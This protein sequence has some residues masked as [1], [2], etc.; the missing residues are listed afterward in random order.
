MAVSLTK[1]KACVIGGSRGK[2]MFKACLVVL[3]T[4]LLVSAKT[5]HADPNIATA[6]S[7]GIYRKLDADF[8]GF[9]SVFFK[10]LIAHRRYD[11]VN[12]ID[13]LLQ[14]ASALQG[15][16]NALDS[17]GLI[18]KNYPAVKK[19]ISSK[20]I[21]GIESLLLA[22]NEFETANS[23]FKLVKD[24]GDPTLITNVQFIFTKYYYQHGDWQHTIELTESISNDL[25]PDELQH[26]KFMEGIALQNQKKHRSAI[27]SFRKVSETSPYY[28]MAQLNMAVSDFRQDWW[29]DAHDIIN[30]LLKNPEITR[31]TELADRLH[32]IIGYSFLQLEY[33][34][35]SRNAFRN[36][37]LNSNYTNKALI[38]IALD[39]AYQKDY[40]GAL[41]AARI[42][43]NKRD[44]TLEVDEAH[45]L[46]PYFYEKLH[47]NAT[48]SAGYTS[49]ITYYEGRIQALQQ[50]AL[51]DIDEKLFAGIDSKNPGLLLNGEVIQLDRTFPPSFFS[52]LEIMREYGKVVNEINN[53]TLHKSYAALRN[54]F[55]TA[56]MDSVKNSLNMKSLYLKDYVNQCRYGLARLY[57]N[58]KSGQK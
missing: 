29:T 26:A 19:H 18:L 5:S 48:A 21:I 10:H 33:F 8:S 47:Q 35:N 40:V 12:D 50:A 32:T 37:S 23:I 6:S 14:K 31:N 41:N 20:A 30:R 24:E 39:A 57:D 7:H 15:T 3:Y 58:S 36:V 53:H 25:P 52:Q 22:E 46:L 43:K 45:L 42:L 13:R 56:I 38:G 11:T 34:R 17:V 44:S 55:N 9:S 4:L 27:K 54:S 49:A 51:Y 2:L 16:D 28:T 1:R